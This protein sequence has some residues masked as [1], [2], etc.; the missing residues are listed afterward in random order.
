MSF[1]DGR[2]CHGEAFYLPTAL[3]HEAFLDTETSAFYSDICL[4]RCA[5]LDDSLRTEWLVRAVRRG[6]GR[7]ITYPADRL[8]HEPG[9]GGRGQ[10]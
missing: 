4:N 9:I 3:S 8:R 7:S 1:S 6:G 5:L 10:C 2:L